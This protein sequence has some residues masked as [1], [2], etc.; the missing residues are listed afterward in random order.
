M[1]ALAGRLAQEH[2]GRS[3]NNTRYW[4]A[5]E[6]QAS[7]N[8]LPAEKAESNGKWLLPECCLEAKHGGFI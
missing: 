2:E 6:S 5:A 8:Y 1:L 3:L 4:R 7:A